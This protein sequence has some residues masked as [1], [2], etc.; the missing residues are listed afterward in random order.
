VSSAAGGSLST[1]KSLKTRHVPGQDGQPGPAAETEMT[2]HEHG[3]D[4]R[5]LEQARAAL[6]DIRKIWGADAPNRANLHL[7]GQVDTSERV[8]IYVPDDGRNPS[9][10]PSRNGA[11]H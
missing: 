8:V 4:P 10:A 6:A 1:Q 2:L 5:Y 7:S 11:A 9:P 3:G